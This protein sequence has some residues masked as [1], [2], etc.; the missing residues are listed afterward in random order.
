M[1]AENASEFGR[2]DAPEQ[3]RAIGQL[4]ADNTVACVRPIYGLIER[5]VGPAHYL[6]TAG[7]A[8]VR[9]SRLQLFHGGTE[10]EHGILYFRFFMA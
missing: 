8:F 1:W 3:E 4:S 5:H 10:R 6:S 9:V 2:T 7:R